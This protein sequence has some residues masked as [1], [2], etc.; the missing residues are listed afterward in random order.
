MLFFNISYITEEF[1][2]GGKT[3]KLLFLNIVPCS[4]VA[5]HKYLILDS[6]FGYNDMFKTTAL[7]LRASNL[8][9][10]YSQIILNSEF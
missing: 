1:K 2:K 3:E 10:A 9:E 7:P 8:L 6:D 5:S 4:Q